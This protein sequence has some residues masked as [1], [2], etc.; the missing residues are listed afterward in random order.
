MKQK[1]KTILKLLFFN[2]ILMLFG[3][4]EEL[5]DEQINKSNI[6]IQ[7]ISMDDTKFKENHK[8]MKS[9]DNLFKTNLTML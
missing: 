4:S 5:F 7:R 3:C 9:V 8:L 6:K 2:T 1:M